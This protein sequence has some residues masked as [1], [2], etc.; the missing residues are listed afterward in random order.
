MDSKF[1]EDHKLKRWIISAPGRSYRPS[2]TKGTEKLCPFCIGFEKENPEVYRIP[3][4][5]ASAGVAGGPDSSDTV[6]WKVRVIKNMY[7]FA[8]VHEIIIHSPDHHKSFDE[9]PLE[10]SQLVLQAYRQRFLEHQ[11]KGYVCIFNNHGEA[12]GE[13]LTHPHSQLVVIPNHVRLEYPHHDIDLSEKT[14][15]TEHFSIFCPK[16]SQWP[17]EVWIYPKERGAYFGEISDNQIKD[18]AKVLYRLIQIMDLRHG[19]EFPYNFYIY[20]DNDWYL[21]LV[22]RIKIIGAFEVSTNVFVNTQDPNETI[23]F[24]IEHFDSPDIEKIKTAHKASYKR[25]V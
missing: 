6:N 16:E 1:I 11:D 2:S 9:L 8:P 24:I 19:N 12:A 15:Q 18:L 21:R 22:P 25:T 23:E 14:K 17:D 5:H 10:Q 4:R 13:S 7:P 20:P 3:A